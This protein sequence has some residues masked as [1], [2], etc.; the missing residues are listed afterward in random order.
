MDRRTL[1]Q[2]MLST[3][4]LAVTAG[5]DVTSL[6]TLGARIHATGS[7]QS[8]RW[9]TLTAAQARTVMLAAEQII[10]RTSTPGATDANV[11]AFIDTMLTD[12]YSEAEARAFVSGLADLDARTL[13]R[14]RAPFAS[15]TTTQ[16]L[17]VLE[18]FDADVTTLRRTRAADANAHWFATLKYLT[19]FGYCTSEPGMRRHLRSH[20]LPMRYDG[21]APV[22]A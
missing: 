6:E 5:L 17:A 11:A 12:W 3:G 4:G 2:W 21:N 15:S 22:N 14:H 10:P 20:P 19:V 1:L 7:A 8:P 9:R 18:S 16:Q 13:Q